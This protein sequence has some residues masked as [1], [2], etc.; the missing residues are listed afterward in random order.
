[1]VGFLVLQPSSLNSNAAKHVQPV[2]A[3]SKI[4]SIFTR[5]FSKVSSY[6]A[7]EGDRKTFLKG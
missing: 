1:M 2:P 5:N 7:G 4:L 6:W 3:L